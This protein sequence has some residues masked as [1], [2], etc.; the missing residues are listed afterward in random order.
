MAASL[1]AQRGFAQVSS[2][3]GGMAAWTARNL[4]LS[5]H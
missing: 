3:A 1:L 5:T 4:P 2:M